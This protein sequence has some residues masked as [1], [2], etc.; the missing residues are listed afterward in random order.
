VRDNT[1]YSPS[2][3]NYR[4]RMASNAGRRMK[5]VEALRYLGVPNALVRIFRALNLSRHRRRR[6][7]ARF[8]RGG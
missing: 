8:K 4:G 6:S 5:H 1:L 2:I 3:E 7:L